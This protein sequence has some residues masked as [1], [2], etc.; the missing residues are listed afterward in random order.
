LNLNVTGSVAVSDTQSKTVRHR[1]E[2]SARMSN[3]PSL[4]TIKGFPSRI[5]NDG[6][7]HIYGQLQQRWENTNQQEA[8]SSSIGSILPSDPLIFCAVIALFLAVEVYFVGRLSGN[9]SQVDRQWSITPAI[10]AWVFAMYKYSENSESY[11]MKNQKSIKPIRLFS[12]PKIKGFPIKGVFDTKIHF[13]LAPHFDVQ[14]LLMAVLVT[15]WSARLTGNFLRKG[16]F[17]GLKFW[18]GEEDYRWEYI[19][20]GQYISILKEGVEFNAGSRGIFSLRGVIFE[21][22][23]IFFIGVFQHLLLLAIVLPSAWVYYRG[24]RGFGVGAFTVEL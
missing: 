5:L 13:D 6:F 4:E 23:H 14:L 22:F 17:A 18:R 11:E 12:I 15:L 3:F 21:L 10:Y 9:L 19:R 8:G 7:L 24:V 2:P 20:K 16:G 1:D